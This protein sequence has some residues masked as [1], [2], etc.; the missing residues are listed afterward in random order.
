MPKSVSLFDVSDIL[1]PLERGDLLL[2]PNH[3]LSSRIKTAYSLYKSRHGQQVSLT[4]NILSLDQWIAKLWL[5]LLVSAAPNVS[6]LQILTADQELMLWRSII[7]NS[8]EAGGFINPLRT[9]QQV[10]SAYNSLLNF[11]GAI[12]DLS[13]YYQTEDT[14]AFKQW[15]QEF[16]ALCVE[17]KW[18][19][20]ASRLQQLVEAFS[21]KTLVPTEKIYTLG[22]DEILPLASKLISTASNTPPI[23]LET[24]SKTDSTHIVSCNDFEEEITSAAV[25]AKQQLRDSETHTVAIVVPELSTQQ[26]TVRRILQ[27][28]FETELLNLKPRR[29]SPFNFSAGT[30]LIETPIVDA[31]LKLLGLLQHSI[32]LKDIYSILNSPFT[33]LGDEHLGNT[34][35]LYWLCANEMT[36]S[37]TSA[38]FRSLASQVDESW[39]F[40][41]QLQI[42]NSLAKQLEIQID[43]SPSQWQVILTQLL[44]TLGWP[45]S[46]TLDSIEFQQVS[47]L[48]RLIDSLP[49]L[50]KSK[51]T[52]SF[53]EILNNLRFLASNHIFQPET[54]DSSLQVLGTLEAAGLQFTHIWLCS[55]SEVQIPAPA[56][57]NAFLPYQMQCERAMPH[58][59][60][61]KEYNFAKKLTDRLIK[62]SKHIVVS[63]PAQLDDATIKASQFFSDFQK[64][65]IQT[66][67]GKELEKLLPIY[68]IHRRQFS[69]RDLEDYDP[70]QAPA[71]KEEGG[72]KGGTSILSQQAACP[73]KAFAKHRLNISSIPQPSIGLSP[74]ERGSLVHKALELIWGRLKTQTA[75]LDQAEDQ[76]I[77][78]CS[79]T[80]H[81]VIE[82][83]DQ[84]RQRALGYKYLSLEKERLAKLL[85]DWLNFEKTRASFIISS[86]ELRQE[87]R[88]AGLKINARID[89]IDQLSDG[90]LLIIDYKT[91]KPSISDWV[92][93]RPDEPQLPLY[94]IM[95]AQQ[96]DSSNVYSALAFAQVNADARK[97]IGIGS[98]TTPETAL[99]WHDKL[100]GKVGAFSWDDLKKQW[101]HTLVALAEAFIAGKADVDPK[102]SP[103]TCQYCDYP[104]VCRYD[105]QTESVEARSHGGQS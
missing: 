11:N 58:A 53:T 84:Y 91:G 1:E 78:L 32:D 76:Q 82:S 75:L 104:S 34:H 45:G 67:I 13:N 26:A 14:L 81:Y 90:S 66:L 29:S 49:T 5:D 41:K 21:N 61:E 93:T 19:Q 85:N 80:A 42:Q 39:Q 92:G 60:A 30:P 101:E 7:E 64:V 59:N 55:M 16:E 65:D 24:S 71:V 17:N 100:K 68:E 10:M 48:H 83:I 89:R 54:A 8:D 96:G 95:S 38:R 9:A 40:A 23:A 69:S 103:S 72:V 37:I 44:Q 3:R 33:S 25:W 35:Q 57:P 6:D 12:D 86:L 74:S 88:F 102:K 46:R 18:L 22:F 2:T 51:P 27:E 63:Y 77:K 4:P 52:Y 97:L 105:Y 62:D 94:G 98:D 50:H 56:A 15:T 87:Y 47:Q 70:G 31:G 79:D 99:Q 43:K 36:Q 73:F 20:S 28:V